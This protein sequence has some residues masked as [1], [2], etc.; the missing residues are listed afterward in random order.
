MPLGRFR[1][2]LQSRG[3]ASFLW[4][5]FL[6]AFNDSVYKIVVTL[7][8]A[9]LA[10]GGSEGRSLALVGT[11]FILPFFLFS[12][13]AGYLADVRNKRS[14]LIGTKSLEIISML[15]AIFALYV[16]DLRFMLA[17]LFLM[18]LQ[19]T[20]FSPAKYG[21]LPEMVPD[22]DLSRANALV[23]M[24]T[25]VAIIL[26]TWLGGEMLVAWKGRTW[27]IGSVLAVIAVGGFLTSFGISRVRDPETKKP[28]QL[29]PWAEIFHGLRRIYSDKPLWLTVLGISY[30]WFLG[31][32]LQLVTIL[33]ARD[34]LVV[35]EEWTARL[36]TFLG[37]GI[38]VGSLAAGRLS[39]DKVELG[40]TPL[41]SIGMGF[42]AIWLAASGSSYLQ[43]GIA[44]SLLGFT[45]GLFIVPLNS[46]LQQK[47]G[48][49]ERGRLI[50]ANNFLSMIGILLASG[51]LYVSSDVFRMAPDRIIFVF[52][53]VTFAV[54][55]YI[56]ATVPDFLIRFC[57]WLFAHTFY[58]IRI[59]G[60]QHV[61]FRG[62]A[63]LVSNHV[64][65]VDGFLVGGCVQRFIRFLVYRPYYE[66]KALNWILR[67]MNTI[68]IQGGDPERVAESIEL[69]R[70]QLRQGHIICI[71]AEG[72]IT[73]TGGM[74]P[75]KRGL[76][77]IIKGL[78]APIIPVNLDR[79]WGSIFSFKEGRFLLRWPERF[80]RRVTVSFGPPLASAATAEDVRQAVMELGSEAA[81]HRVT[82]RDQLHLRFIRTAKRHWFSLAATDA[83]G[84]RLSYGGVLVE[85][86][87]T[88]GWLRRQLDGG[89][90]AGERVGLLVPPSTEGAVGNVAVLLGGRVP[91]NLNYRD[92]ERLAEALRECGIET[93]ICSR[94]YSPRNL[95]LGPRILYLEDA[96]EHT[97]T[98]LRALVFIAIFVLPSRLLQAIYREKDVS[99]DSMATVVYTAGKAAPPKPV[100]LSHQNILANV[101]SMA[102]LFWVANTDRVVGVLP[103]HYA[104]G[105]TVTLWFPLLTGCGVIYH[106]DAFDPR[107]V[108]KLIRSLQATTIVGTPSMY[109]TY[110]RESSQ[111]DFASLRYA[112]LG[113][114]AA[115]ESLAAEFEGKF[116]LPLMEGYGCTEMSPV[117]AVNVPNFIHGRR[118][119]IGS[120]PGTVGHPVP[121][122]STKVVDPD[123]GETLP[124]DAE[125][126]LLVKGPSLMNGYLGDA[127]KTG[128]VMRGGWFVTGDTAVVDEDGFIRI[129]KK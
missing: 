8:A 101:D 19:S 35:G 83:S 31:A 58:N 65:Y 9:N 32:L 14:V 86:L 84:T 112:L 82:P 76:E 68:P 51:A 129:V 24:S 107:T 127:A 89:K 99:P 93:V 40:L 94:R 45:A 18:A 69:A 124:S 7:L 71:F 5:Q 98:A 59:I 55:I 95:P 48:A 102:Q 123:T 126:M 66:M 12:G 6:G 113:G 118:R 26:G 108:G 34:V 73:R 50:A 2:L 67:R 25:N 92:P 23:Q 13:Y 53:L 87:L 79:L 1:T 128:S 104:F 72:S 78:D 117:V 60:Q 39:G 91:I 30:F 80:P 54:T 57:L 27:L 85:A 52:G 22:K 49:D 103:F 90:P 62:P 111:E 122:V 105:F 100:I 29:N 42:A 64:S 61:P 3:F 28:F 46:L 37:V 96:L 120:K 70:E 77:R 114:E 11:V 43:A 20:L 81:A 97:S 16:Q 47:S 119:Q 106:D 36:I 17:V 15:L 38:G 110:V 44:M 33:F 10:A 56:L 63:L 125:G 41:G 74:L 4:T 116:G 121:A 88:A 21:I 115:S 109:A 75:F